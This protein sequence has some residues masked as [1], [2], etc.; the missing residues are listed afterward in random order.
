MNKILVVD[1]EPVIL[2]AIADRLKAKGYDVLTAETGEEGYDKTMQFKP[3][4]VVL[5]VLLPKINGWEVCQKLKADESVKHIPVIILTV[6][7]KEID[8]I[9]SFECGAEAY[10]TK[11]FEFD[12]LLEKIADLL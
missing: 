7:A 2:R 6:K 11:P 4:L 3:D 10:M 9:K 8:E 5:D 1:D 12:R